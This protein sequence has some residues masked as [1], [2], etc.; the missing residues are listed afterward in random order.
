MPELQQAQQWLRSCS[1]THACIAFCMVIVF[2]SA[3]G[4]ART[5]A[6]LTLQ[7]HCQDTNRTVQ[8]ARSA[9]T[10][11]GLTGQSMQGL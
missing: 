4:L 8:V 1:H 11:I 2:L 9:V 10:F 3:S 5:Q 6:H 7:C